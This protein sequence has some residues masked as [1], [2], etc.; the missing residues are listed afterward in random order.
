MGKNFFNKNYK[1]NSNNRKW[2]DEYID[3]ALDK[4]TR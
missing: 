2:I 4:K 1:K 3:K